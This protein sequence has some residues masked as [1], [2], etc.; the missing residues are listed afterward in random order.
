MFVITMF[1]IAMYVNDQ[2]M[3]GAVLYEDGLKIWAM[4]WWKPVFVLSK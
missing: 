2:E 1:V 3:K 4:L